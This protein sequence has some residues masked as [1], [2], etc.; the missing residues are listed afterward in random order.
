M[1]KILFSLI[2]SAI[3][4]GSPLAASQAVVFYWGD[5]MGSFDR[6]LLVDFM[7]ESIHFTKDEFE[8]AN[9][10][11]RK[12]LDNGQPD[13]DYWLELADKKMITLPETW[14][15]QYLA[16][17]ERCV[18]VNSSM[19][20]LVNELQENN[21]PV[22]LLSNATE[23]QAA[24]IRKMGLYKPF[25][26]C[27]ISCEIGIEKPDQ[28]AFEILV[29]TIDLSAEEIVFIDDKAENVEAAKKIGLDAI[30]F[31]SSTQVREELSKR[32]LLK[33]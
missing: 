15:N 20:A 13:V 2:A 9:R 23:R 33:K 16:M 1:K 21:V 12:A 17:F 4:N 19:Y 7:C 27:L 3:T 18:D 8:Q 22:A 11:K 31:K 24:V 6:I 26:P 14:K 30:V 32:A 28:K 25:D 10:E 29:K 5:V